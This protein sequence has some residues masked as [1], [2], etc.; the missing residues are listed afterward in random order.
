MQDSSSLALLVVGKDAEISMLREQL[1]QL[2]ADL[3][4]NLAVSFARHC[5]FNEVL[6]RHWQTT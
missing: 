4:R 5:R 1:S 3:N 6:L 2:S